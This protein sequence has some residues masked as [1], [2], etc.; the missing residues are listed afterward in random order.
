MYCD[1]VVATR[2]RQSDSLASCTGILVDLMEMHLDIIPHPE[3]VYKEPAR[4]QPSQSASPLHNHQSA[5]QHNLSPVESPKKP[6]QSSP[7]NTQFTMQL[8]IR[9]FLLAITSLLLAQSFTTLAAPITVRSARSGDVIGHLSSRRMPDSTPQTA[10]GNPDI[11]PVRNARTGRT[12]GHLSSRR[13]VPANEPPQ[14]ALYRR[15]WMDE[16]EYD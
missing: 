15:E 4:T 3:R 11:I 9:T 8:N 2:F 10:V 5:G 16:V 14:G 6:S 12:I 13:R 7:N 1:D